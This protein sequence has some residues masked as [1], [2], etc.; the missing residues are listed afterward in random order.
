M[1]ALID[2]HEDKAAGPDAPD[3]TTAIAPHKG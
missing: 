2:E 3:D 1:Q